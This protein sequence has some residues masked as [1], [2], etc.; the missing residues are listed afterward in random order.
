[1]Y[2]LKFSTNGLI[3]TLH[4]GLKTCYNKAVVVQKK[5]YVILEKKLG[6]NGQKMKNK[7]ISGFFSF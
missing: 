5:G 6:K 7:I 2:V 4:A 1:M 3:H